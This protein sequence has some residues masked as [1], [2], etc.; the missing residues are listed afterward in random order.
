MESRRPSSRTKPKPR[1]KSNKNPPAAA[2]TPEHILQLGLGFWGSKTLLSAVEL[3]LF[4][5]LAK[6]P[7]EGDTLRRRLSLHQRGACDFFDALVAL[8]MLSRRNQRYANTPNADFFLDRTKPSYIGGM[9]EM[10]NARLYPFWG[11]LTT[12]LRTG[13][14]QSEVRTGETFYQALYRDPAAMKNFLEAMTG[15]S[16]GACQALARK[17]P[18]KK[19]KTFADIGAAQGALP[20]QLALAHPHLRGVGFD[21][22]VCRP[23]FDEYVSAYGLADRIVF[24]AGSF[25]ADPLPEADVLIMGHILHGE[26]VDD[27]RR[28]IAKA[29]RALP[30]GGAYLVLEELIDNERTEN[31]FALLMSLNILI[32]TPSGFNC[33]AADYQ[34][35]M[36]EAGFRTTSV[37]PLVGPLGLVVAIKA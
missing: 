25:L 20:V 8:G 4:T 26:S 17:F 11:K 23:I 28:L 14:P 13:L 1:P 3:G 31:A 36:A 15:I 30:K 22:P 16:L 32:E 12:A 18:W 21:L 37:V 6:G 2:L 35:W 29:Y 9:L 19:Y 10:A 33:T 7:L 27:K 24:Q 5:E 34:G